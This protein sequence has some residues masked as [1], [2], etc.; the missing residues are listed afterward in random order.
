MKTATSGVESVKKNNTAY[1]KFG[2]LRTE[3]IDST[4]EMF[5][6]M[7]MMAPMLAKEVEKEYMISGNKVM[8]YQTDVVG[9]LTN[10]SIYHLDTRMKERYGELD[11]E[12]VYTEFA[13]S[14]INEFSEE[15]TVVANTG[16]KGIHGFNCS[17]FTMRNQD[18]E[19][20]TYYTEDIPMEREFPGGKSGFPLEIHLIM[21]GVNTITG[22]EEYS[23]TLP[24]PEFFNV[25]KSEYRKITKEEFPKQRKKF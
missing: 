17:S 15:E 24:H 23:S 7:E 25:D 16:T 14:G 13:D 21:G 10:F 8:E 1:F 2:I 6:M 4:N 20:I 12:K 19:V 22:V 3:V 5:K 9:D 18:M 11:L